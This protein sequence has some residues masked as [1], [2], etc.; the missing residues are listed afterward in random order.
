MSFFEGGYV[1]GSVVRGLTLPSRGEW[2][3]LGQYYPVSDTKLRSFFA[4]APV[5]NNQFFAGRLLNT[6]PAYKEFIKVGD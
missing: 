5:S 2:R 3:V 6:V 1:I 4:S